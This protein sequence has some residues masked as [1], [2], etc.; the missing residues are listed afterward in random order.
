MSRATYEPPGK[1]SPARVVLAPAALPGELPQPQTVAARR[2]WRAAYVR[3]LVAADAGTALVAVAV[4]WATTSG[5]APAVALA[6]PVVWVAALFVAR[7]YDR[8]VLWEG[9]EEFRR[10]FVGAVLV[11]GGAALFAWAGQVDVPR[12]FVALT[13]PLGTALTLGHRYAQRRLLRRARAQGRHPQTTLLVGHALG[14]AGLHEQLRRQA[15]LGYQVIGC[16][17]PAG[18]GAGMVFSGLPVLGGPGDVVDVVRRYDVDTVAVLP[19]AELDGAALRRL[20]W[21]LEKTRAE[22]LLAPTVTEIAGPRVRIRPVC[23]LPLLH[24]ERPEL[25]GPRRVVKA[26]FDR[27]GAAL[28]VF[29]LLPVLLTVALAVK[30]GSRG[31]VLFRQQRVGRD[32]RIFP[33]LKFRTME[34]DAERRLAQ[35][36]PHSDGNGVLFKMRQDPRV[37]RIGR[38]LRR[39]SLD[40][41]PQLLNVLAGHMSLVGPRPPLPTEVE[42]YGL[43]MRRRFVVKPGL[44][45]LWQV[46]GRSAL[47]WEESVRVDVHYVEN[48]SLLLDLLILWRTFGAVIRGDGAY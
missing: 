31:P 32:G 18:S 33:M 8:N 4:G 16:C 14:V 2:A 29:L 34:V 37:T 43:D 21:D 42:R 39:Y 10:V 45:G 6:L 46:S 47:S 30:V 48:W 11:L 25:H 5:V 40:E 23:G 24:M 35:L 28:I 38:L 36:V 26:T 20:G 17:L 27:A 7:G 1:V 15:G 19:S 44:T 9:T 41:L 22:L 12:G 13:L 3:R